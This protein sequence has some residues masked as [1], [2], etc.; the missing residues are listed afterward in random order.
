[1]GRPF[2]VK[3]GIVGNT[4]KSDVFR[5]ILEFVGLL[6]NYSIEACFSQDLKIYFNNTEKYNYI[7]NAQ[8]GDECDFVVTFGGDG[9]MLST[10]K[11]IGKSNTPI[12]GVN[13]G[14]LG[15]LAEIVLEDMNA[16]IEA[17]V[18]GDYS[19]TERMML[20]GTVHTID[21]I[22]TKYAL[23]DFVVDKGSSAR[24]LYIETN[25][26]DTLLNNYRADGVIVSTPT[27]STAYSLS[28]GGPILVPNMQA[29]VVTP[30]CP[31]SLTVRPIVLSDK[32]VLKLCISPEQAPAQLHFDGRG[33]RNLQP[34]EWV[35][36][37]K[38]DFTV[39]WVSIG[40][41]DFY[42]IIRTKLNWGVDLPSFNK[43]NGTGEK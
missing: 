21:H 1:M 32:S 31:H 36:I 27:G 34:G 23:N 19:L 24:L 16:A 15:F 37:R 11:D 42:E 35:E 22:E 28:A 12:L 3:I 14:G 33:K 5:V 25:V 6:K 41:H 38:A 7:E 8:M 43:P 30:I 9:T 17:L 39:K 26:D 10:I 13:M 20:E 29:I 18:N 4:Q 40:K 2:R